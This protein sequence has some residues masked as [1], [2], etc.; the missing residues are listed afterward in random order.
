MTVMRK[1]ILLVS[2][3]IAMTVSIGCKSDDKNL[4][5]QQ[6]PYLDLANLWSL[7]ESDPQTVKNSINAI[8]VSER[9]SVD[10]KDGHSICIHKYIKNTACGP[11]MISCD[12]HDEKLTRLRL[13]SSLHVFPD[14][15]FPHYMAI[16]DELYEFTHSYAFPRESFYDASVCLGGEYSSMDNS[17]ITR[18]SRDDRDARTKYLK[19]VNECLE[20]HKP[21]AS[22]GWLFDFIEVVQVKPDGIGSIGNDQ[23]PEYN[24]AIE[25]LLFADVHGGTSLIV[26]IEGKSGVPPYYEYKF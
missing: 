4:H 5:V 18:F 10:E 26:V 8:F 7:Y 23:Q 22:Y 11:Y 1:Y 6:K 3:I 15:A 19:Y 9:D 21:P 17:H 14:E 16:S 13:N 12:F 24:K 20:T 25:L 2:L